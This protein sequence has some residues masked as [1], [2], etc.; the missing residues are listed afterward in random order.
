MY[1]SI[2]KEELEA[3]LKKHKQVEIM[4]IL[5]IPYHVLKRL[6]T[7]YGIYNYRLKQTVLPHEKIESLYKNGLRPSE[8][9]ARYGTPATQISQAVSKGKTSDTL[10][11]ELLNM[12]G[13]KVSN[14][15]NS[16]N[17]D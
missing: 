17:F 14:I 5:N 12:M 4:K 2:P 6:M 1:K 8:I 15:S 16:L 7:G 3:L 11:Q 10:I 13:I 9:R